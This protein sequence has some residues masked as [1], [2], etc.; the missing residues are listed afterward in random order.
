MIKYAFSES[1]L[2]LRTTTATVSSIRTRLLLPSHAKVPL[3]R[4]KH[5]RYIWKARVY[6]G[7]KIW[8]NEFNRP[9]DGA[10]VLG[11]QPND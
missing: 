5:Y 9:A 2:D 11:C 10:V 6:R 1:F 4:G 3:D 7:M 8:G